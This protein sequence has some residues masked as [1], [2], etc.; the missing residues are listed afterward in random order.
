MKNLLVATILSFLI[1]NLPF[2]VLA[3][4]GRSLR[5]AYVSLGLPQAPLWI[6]NEANY[7]TEAGLR[8][9]TLFIQNSSV[10]IQ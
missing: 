6:A 10:A 2:S 3:S 1:F 8:V 4:H 5:V 7:F 9:E